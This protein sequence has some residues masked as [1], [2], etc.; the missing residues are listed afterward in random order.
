MDPKNLA[1]TAAIVYLGLYLYST[2]NLPGVKK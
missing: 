1:I 2:G